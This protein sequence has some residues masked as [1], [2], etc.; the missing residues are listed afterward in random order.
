MIIAVLSLLLSLVGLFL[1]AW[2]LLPAP[3]AFWL[4]LSVGAPEVSPWLVL[5]NLLGAGIALGRKVKLN[6]GLIALGLSM[7]GLVFSLVPL[8]QVAAATTT[9]NTQMTA[10]LGVD[11]LDPLPEEQQALMRPHPVVLAALWR[12]IPQPN[13]VRRDRN[14]P[15]AQPNGIPL[16]LDLYRPPNPAPAAGYPGV[17]MIYGGAWQRGQPSD[18]GAFADY[19]ASQGYV[20]WAISYRHAPEY[21]FP[22]QIE[23]VTAALGFVQQMA[24]RYETD[25]R[26]IALMGRSAGAHLAMLAAYQGGPLPVQAVVN[27]YGPVDLLSGYY[28]LPTPD[29]LDVRHVLRDFLDGPPEGPQ[30]IAR[31]QAASPLTYATRPQPPSLLIYGGKD[32]VVMSRFG[33]GLANRLRA[34]GSKAVFLEIPWADHAF[35][36]VF[37]G[38]SNQW[39]LYYTERFLAWA[40]A[41]ERP[42][43]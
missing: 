19:L 28:D 23:D 21:P 15:F 14:I 31:Y 40:L 33:Q 25:P 22:A 39:A 2:I 8:G 5:I 9:A 32:R 38:L 10:V 13:G 4:P 16:T 37:N 34:T 30:Q 1:S 20:V 7:M 35:D 29:P 41:P 17:V 11:Y 27:Y 12:G 3:S 6:Y 43:A 42:E 18:N 24:E 26:R 36:A